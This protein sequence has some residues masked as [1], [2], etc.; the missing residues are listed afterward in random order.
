MKLPLGVA[1]VHVGIQIRFAKQVD[2]FTGLR[3]VGPKIVAVS[4][5]LGLAHRPPLTHLALGD[6]ADPGDGA[7][8]AALPLASGDGAGRHLSAP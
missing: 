7:A 5:I 3:F 4:T 2:S 8:G 6:V 1:V